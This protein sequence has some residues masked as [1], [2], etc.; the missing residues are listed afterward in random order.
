MFRRLSDVLRSFSEND[1][2]DGNPCQSNYV[3]FLSSVDPCPDP[4]FIR[5]SDARADSEAVLVNRYPGSLS[6]LSETDLE[7][8]RVWERTDPE[9]METSKVS[10]LDDQSVESGFSEQDAHDSP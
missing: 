4:S 8:Y 3:C 9:G 5:G 6:T 1:N 10:E 7:T 2:D